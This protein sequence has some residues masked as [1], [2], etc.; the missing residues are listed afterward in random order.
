MTGDNA[1]NPTSLARVRQERVHAQR[2][3]TKKMH[4]LFLFFQRRFFQRLFVTM[5]HIVNLSIAIYLRPDD[6]DDLLGPAN[7]QHI[8]SWFARGQRQLY[9]DALC[10]VA[11]CR[12][13]LFRKM[14]TDPIQG[15]ELS[16]PT[17]C[18]GDQ[19]AGRIKTIFDI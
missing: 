16:N 5:L 6:N 4:Y 17:T 14:C 19:T 11:W 10:K 9:T 2:Q 3:S 13:R 1:R 15:S 7:A 18:D 12:N 8:V